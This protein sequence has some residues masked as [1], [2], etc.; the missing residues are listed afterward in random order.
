MTSIDLWSSLRDEAIFDQYRVLGFVATY[1]ETNMKII[2]SFACNTDFGMIWKVAG[3][4]FIFS[5]IILCSFG[6]KQVAS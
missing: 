1:K 4:S 3:I 2:D 5:A 6:R